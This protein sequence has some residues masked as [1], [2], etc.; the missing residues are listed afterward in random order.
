MSS[1]ALKPG[2]ASENN[3]NLEIRGGGG[4][5][6]PPGPDEGSS[7]VDAPKTRLE[8]PIPGTGTDSP[9][10][11]TSHSTPHAQ[12]SKSAWTAP[13][14]MIHLTS[15]FPRIIDYSAADP[16]GSLPSHTQGGQSGS[17]E[18]VIEQDAV[19]EGKSDLGSLVA[20]A[21][22]LTLRG[23]RE[24]ADAFPPLKAVAGGLCFILDNCEVWFISYMPC[25]AGRSCAL[26][27]Q[28]HATRRLNCCHLGLQIS[29][30]H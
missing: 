25:K 26:S 28:W 16:I 18:N 21:A 30:N 27:K 10:F 9:S 5:E 24:A 20:S 4:N 23:V 13:S 22:K 8:Q 11:P 29:R 17:P 7:N 3:Q 2:G 15:P 14:Q 1:T 6:I 19:G 12:D